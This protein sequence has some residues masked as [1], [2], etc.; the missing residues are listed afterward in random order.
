MT[1]HPAGEVSGFMKMS[2]SF[3]I[4]PSLSQGERVS[5]GLTQWRSICGS[6]GVSFVN[7]C[8]VAHSRNNRWMC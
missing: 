2:H 4:I 8:Y 6:A 1:V 7:N 5:D 3:E